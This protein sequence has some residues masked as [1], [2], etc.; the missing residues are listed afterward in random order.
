MRL[1]KKIPDATGEEK[2]REEE[3]NG[4]R[5]GEKRID[6]RRGGGG[7][8]ISLSATHTDTHTHT[9]SVVSSCNPKTPVDSSNTVF[10]FSRHFS[11]L[12]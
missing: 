12:N 4:G 10:V 8:L 3:M 11:Q 6:T 2:K 9:A 1:D 7:A 5:I